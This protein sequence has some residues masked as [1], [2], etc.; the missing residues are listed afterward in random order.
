MA[1]LFAARL[2][3]SDT[4]VTLLGTWP[5]G[6]QALNRC[7]VRVLASDGSEQ[8][9][10]VRATADPAECA[11]ARLALVL[12]KS[13]QTERAARQLAAC[14]S[15]DGLALTLQNGLGNREKLAEILGVPRVALGVTTIGATL[16]GPGCVRP[17][18]EGIVSLGANPRLDPLAN[19]LWRAG[20]AVETVP[21]ADG[22]L[23]SKLVIN[24]AIN[25]L[26][27]LLHVSN[28]ELLV[29][30]AARMLMAE[31]AREAAAVAM[32]LNMHLV[33]SDSVAA[34]EAVA[35]RTAINHSSMFQ[36]VTRG[37]PTEIDAI[38]GAI[39]AEGERCQVPTPVNRTLW[40]LVKALR[41]EGS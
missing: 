13:W 16:V 20:F 36:D 40:L 7:G 8:S 34:V 29:R 3:A 37:A 6:L 26:T 31:A 25:P 38:C 35:Q 22:L 21:D 23:W 28:G 27:A 33:F 4:R 2:A 5:E 18:G 10:P 14:L 41:R 24:A 19:L 39:A 12:V 15:P 9:Y 32:A 11:G 17:G 1:C 30:P